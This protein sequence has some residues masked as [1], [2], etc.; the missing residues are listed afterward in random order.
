M[1]LLRWSSGLPPSGLVKLEAKRSHQR[2]RIKLLNAE[3]SHQRGRILL[4][5]EL[6]DDSEAKSNLENKL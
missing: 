1:Q 4:L 2:R 6:L 3:R 5:N